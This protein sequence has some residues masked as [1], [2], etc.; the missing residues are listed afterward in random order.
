MIRYC[1]N[2]LFPE[3]KQDLTLD[4][5]GICSA[6]N[7]VKIKE[8]IDWKTKWQELTNIFDK[9]RSKDE[10]NYDCI[11]PVSGGKDS[12]Y[13][14]H[15]VK[16]E[17]GMNPLLVAFRPREWTELGRKNLENLKIKL[18]VD[19][20]EFTPKR[21]LYKQI[22]KVGFTYFG[23]AS[24]PEHMGIFTVPVQIAVKFKIPLIIWG[25]NS[26]A[27][28]GGPLED[29]ERNFQDIDWHKK[30]GETIYVKN[31]SSGY[32]N[33]EYMLEHGAKMRDLLPYVYPSD[34]EILKVGVTGLYLGQFLKWDG[35]KQL[36]KMKQ[37][38]GFM[39]HDGPMEGTYTNYENLDN[40][41]Q[42]LHDYMKWVKF[43]YGRAT[44]QASIQIRHKTLEREEG[45]TLVKKYEGKIPE[46]YLEEYLKDFEITREEF[47]KI[48][49]KHTN[50]DLF[51]K[52]KNGNLLRDENWNL[53]KINYDNVE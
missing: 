20:I 38:Y 15:V 14:T 53:E 28:Y 6:C 31:Q 5:N 26:Q 45:L 30:Y 32:R 27:E 33:I 39:V 48:V 37:E 9:F 46:R 16:K 24:W 47:F 19:C 49:D 35:I 4:E 51:K 22:Q 21:D 40:K 7:Y 23:D 11:I 42:G 17:F 18:D 34:E 50:F 41:G 43:G 3:T 8:T 52:D 12:M 13:Q 44:D 29:Q 1:K 25:E 2:C 10:K 36:Q